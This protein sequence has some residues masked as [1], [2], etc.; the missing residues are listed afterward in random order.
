MK[1]ADLTAAPGA[2]TAADPAGLSSA[3]EQAIAWAVRFESGCATA[4]DR[5]ACGTWRA[6]APAHEQAWQQ[7]QHIEQAFRALPTA[8]SPGLAYDTLQAA[9]R[10]RGHGVKRRRAVKLLS[11][12]LLLGGTGLMGVRLAPAWRAHSSYASAV[13]ERRRVALADGSVLQL[14]TGTEIEVVFTPLRRL[15]LL[16]HGEV[17][18]DTGSDTQSLIGRRPFWVETSEARL[19]ALGT[20]FHVRQDRIG[21]TGE[22]RLHV[23]DGRVAMHAGQ[24]PTRVIAHPGETL[25][26][27]GSEASPQRVLDSTLDATAWID[28]VLVARRMRLDALLAELARYRSAPL[29]CDPSV[30]ALR[31]SGVFRLDGPDPVGRALQVL[32]R[33]LPVRVAEGPGAG[34]TLVAR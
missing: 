9:E 14:N 19:E 28:G 18:I 7:V 32:A 30:S 24:P 1:A 2:G 16:R 22:T 23:V 3:L 8:R 6:S 25:R 17:F 27:S 13:G 15:V 12:G 5:A 20:R 26:V 21:E 31:V 29:H 4:Q 10:L 33:T 11:L 34:R